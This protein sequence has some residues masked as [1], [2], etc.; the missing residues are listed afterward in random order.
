[1]RHHYPGMSSI[2]SVVTLHTGGILDPI[3]KKTRTTTSIAI[4]TESNGFSAHRSYQHHRPKLGLCF[5]FVGTLD[6]PVFLRFYSTSQ[7]RLA[8]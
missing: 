1:M 7:L 6:S 4:N 2:R 8:T 3:H 5:L